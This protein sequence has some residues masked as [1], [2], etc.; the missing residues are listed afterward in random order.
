[1]KEVWLVRHGETEWSLSG[2][3]T[4]RTDIP[5]TAAGRA[6]AALLRYRLAAQHFDLVLT[7]PLQRAAETAALAGFSSAE[8]CADLVEWDYG[9]AEG[10][11]SAQVRELVPT[12][13]IW[14]HGAPV[15]AGTVPGE[16]KSQARERLARVVERLREAPGERAL[17]F[18]HGHALRALTTIWC[19]MP[20]EAGAHFPLQTATIGTLGYEKETPAIVRWNA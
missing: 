1:M 3:H 10:L 5:L 9:P 20:I 6:A 19:G 11:T 17:L 4:G 2:R 8:R 13:R 15:I 16:T 7:S 18:G 14:T 12:W